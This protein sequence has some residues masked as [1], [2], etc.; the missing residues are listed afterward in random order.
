MAH[1]TAKVLCKCPHEFQD[2]TYGKNVRI[3][4]ATEKSNEQKI[5]VRCTV[6]RTVHSVNKSQVK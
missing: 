1:G 3:A 6:C 5:D 2:A 4:N